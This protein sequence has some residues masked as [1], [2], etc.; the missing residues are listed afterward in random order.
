MSAEPMA[1]V[2]WEPPGEEPTG[3]LLVKSR[4]YNA[5]LHDLIK[6]SGLT[7]IE[8]AESIGVTKSTIGGYLT[9]RISPWLKSGEPRHDAQ[10]LAI[11]L[12]I[13]FNELFPRS[14]YALRQMVPPEFLLRRYESAV[15]VPLIEAR[16]VPALENS[17][18]TISE[19][20]LREGVR[21]ALIGLTPREE[22]VLKQRFGLDGNG[23]TYQEIGEELNVSKE[24]VHR[25]EARALEKLRHPSHSK[26]LKAFLE[27]KPNGHKDDSVNTGVCRR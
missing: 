8:Y 4:F 27:T 12:E 18:Q 11:R 16:N 9:L 20:E 21:K 24:Q 7:Q 2:Q 22:F 15:L 25:I 26:Y 17:S 3:D 13:P 1:L 10:L 23:C 6:K 5:L 14:L 19:E